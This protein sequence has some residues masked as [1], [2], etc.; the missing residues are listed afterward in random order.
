MQINRFTLENGLRALHYQD[1]QSTT[2]VVNILYNVGSKDETPDKTGFAHL[3]EHLMFGGSVN[4]PHYDKIAENAG[5]SNNAYTNNDITNYYISVPV[6]NIETAL[7]LESDRMLQLDFSQK[8]LDVQIG[9]VTEEFKQRCFNAPFGQL[10]HHLRKM[11][12]P[13]HPYEWPTIGEKIEHITDAK[14]EDVKAFYAKHY[15]PNNA[16]I[17][18]CSPLEFSEV[19]ALIEK[20]F[21]DIPNQGTP[22]L[23]QYPEFTPI[24]KPVLQEH[25]DLC[26]N[27][28]VFLA[29]KGENYLSKTSTHLEI[30]AEMLGGSETAPL[31][32]ELVKKSALFNAAESFYLRTHED[33]MFV[34]Y[35]VLNEGVS[36]ETGKDKLLEVLNQTMSLNGLE[37]HKLQK[38][39]NQLTTQFLFQNTQLMTV[40]QKLCSYEL[41]GDVNLYEKEAE[42]YET[43]TLQDIL[44]SANATLTASSTSILYYT[45][46]SD[47]A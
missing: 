32:T 34:L 4:I 12:Y 5:A 2:A 21:G 25:T 8:S 38:T 30:F 17:S 31:Y 39:K 29:W 7:W 19:K 42:Q 41:L 36:H 47:K 22:N 11:V 40:A 18:V 9:V 43:P 1:L 13:G 37:E 46:K 3:F 16:I 24:T 44:N 33:G 20:W 28:A 23:N 10:W 45:P 26:P 15:N 6:E 14:L 27:N 35:G